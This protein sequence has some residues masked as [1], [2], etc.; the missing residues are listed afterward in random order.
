MLTISLSWLCLSSVRKSGS[1][2]STRVSAFVEAN[3][4]R[5]TALFE[6]EGVRMPLGTKANHGKGFT[7]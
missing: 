2:A 5:G 7:F 1:R 4:D 6:V 3:D